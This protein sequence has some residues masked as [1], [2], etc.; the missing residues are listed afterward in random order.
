MPIL[1]LLLLTLDPEPL[2]NPTQLVARLGFTKPKYEALLNEHQ[3][4]F[5]FFPAN[6]RDCRSIALYCGRHTKGIFH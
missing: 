2:F 4:N 6:R 1:T 3:G 5:A